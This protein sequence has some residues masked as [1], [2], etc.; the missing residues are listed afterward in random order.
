MQKDY[1]NL[2]YKS[3]KIANIYNAFSEILIL[4]QRLLY[5]K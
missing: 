3:I 1:P 5:N 4:Y 2:N